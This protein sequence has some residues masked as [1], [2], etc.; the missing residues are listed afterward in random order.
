MMTL[1]DVVFY[2]YQSANNLKDH[3]RELP[4]TE[5][6]RARIAWVCNQNP[7][8]D[9]FDDVVEGGN[10]TW[11]R[12]FALSIDEAFRYFEDSA[13]RR[14][15]VTPYAVE[16][17]SYINSNYN[18]SRGRGTGWWWLRSPGICGNDAAYVT[19][20]GDVF[21][22]GFCVSNDSVSVRPALW[23]HL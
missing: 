14:T 18:K 5:E 4:V 16:K 7:D 19:P 21:G 2:A 17:S 13:D 9:Y 23:L 12:V 6:E 3:I 11:D 15:P 20:D 1:E 22:H 8:N 10:P